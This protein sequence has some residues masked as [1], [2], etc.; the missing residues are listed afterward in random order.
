MF[1]F[2]SLKNEEKK[3]TLPLAAGVHMQ[4]INAKP[5]SLKLI[6]P[7]YQTWYN[8]FLLQQNSRSRLIS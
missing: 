2:L 1:L 6:S 3:A 4:I 8:I 7:T 5:G